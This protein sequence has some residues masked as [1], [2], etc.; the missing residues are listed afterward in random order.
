ML[1]RWTSTVLWVTKSACAISR[2]V[3]PSAASSATRRSLGVSDSTPLRAMRRGRAPVARSSLS[4]RA[5]SGRGAADRR[6]LERMPK[7]LAGLGAAVGSAKRRSQLGARLRVLE[8]R[9][10]PAQHVDRFLEQLEP[11]LAALDEACRTQ[12]RAE[13]PR[14]TPR[15]R[16]LDLFLGK[17]AGLV[18]PA[19]LKQSQRGGRAPRDEGGVPAADLL[20][21]ASGLEHLLEAPGQVSAQQAQA[22]GAVAEEE[23]ARAAG[24]SFAG[25]GAGQNGRGF[26]EPALLHQRVG[27]KG[28]RVPR[29]A[30]SRAPD[31]PCGQG[32]ARFGL[33]LA[34]V[35]T[36]AQREGAEDLHRTE[37]ERRAVPVGLGER[38]LVDREDLVEIR[39][40]EHR[41]RRDEAGADRY[42]TAR[43]SAR[44][45]VPSASALRASGTTSAAGLPAR[46]SW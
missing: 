7:L 21:Q 16:E 46:A 38:V 1:V 11:A 23:Q 22:P 37:C 8:L 39:H 26:V 43:W 36:P 13:R 29:E 45:I 17:R 34:E 4:A 24:R 19:E 2:F 6:Q 42:G 14:G 28:G 32:L 5:A 20:E 3:G 33:R 12:G 44:R 27:E 35:A 30:S 31:L 10:R 18:P 15:A 41:A 40:R 9:R 25:P